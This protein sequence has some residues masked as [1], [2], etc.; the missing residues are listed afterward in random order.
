MS[1]LPVVP[2]PQVVAAR[3]LLNNFIEFTPSRSSPIPRVR[4]S[5]TAAGLL[6]EL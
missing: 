5:H 6:K 1:L 2:S 3:I 4:W